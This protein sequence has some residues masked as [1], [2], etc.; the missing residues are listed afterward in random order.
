MHLSQQNRV[1][2]LAKEQK[3]QL[4]VQPAEI[5]LATCLQVVL[6]A[7]WAITKENYDDFLEVSG[8]AAIRSHYWDAYNFKLDQIRA[9]NA[10]QLMNKNYNES[11]MFTTGAGLDQDAPED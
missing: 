1:V 8:V 11:K 9:E 2:D 7:G 3:M 10:Q 4:E 6:N 5:K